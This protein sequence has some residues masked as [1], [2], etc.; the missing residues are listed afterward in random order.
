[1]ELFKVIPNPIC[2][3]MWKK[4]FTLKM[5]NNDNGCQNHTYTHQN[6]KCSSFFHFPLSSNKK[7]NEIQIES[8]RFELKKM[9][10]I[11]SFICCYFICHRLTASDPYFILNV[12]EWLKSCFKCVLENLIVKLLSIFWTLNSV[13]FDVTVDLDNMGQKHDEFRHTMHLLRSK[14]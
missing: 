4:K 2:V 6:K 13:L 12:T 8:E 1:M 14:M 10:S 7:S 5:R 11:Y 3:D 9:H